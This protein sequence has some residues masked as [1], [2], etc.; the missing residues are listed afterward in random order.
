MF[1]ELLSD[2]QKKD[3]TRE[4]LLSKNPIVISI[5]INEGHLIN[6][7][8]QEVNAIIQNYIS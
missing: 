5:L 3:L 7:E 8:I 2:N 4:A 1:Y 6:L